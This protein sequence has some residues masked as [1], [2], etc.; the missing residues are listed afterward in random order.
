MGSRD[1]ELLTPAGRV[2]VTSWTNAGSASPWIWAWLRFDAAAIGLATDS[3]RTH[4]GRRAEVAG[5][6]VTVTA[7][8]MGLRTAWSSGWTARSL[9]TLPSSSEWATTLGPVLESH[10]L[11]PNRTNVQFARVA[12]RHTIE[13]AIWERGA[14]FT[15]VSGT[16]SC[17]AAAAAI[18]AERC[19]SPVTVRMPGGEM[20]VEIDEGWNVRL[21]GAARQVCS[22]EWYGE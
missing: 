10:P 19:E 20:L 15:L 6:D 5:H 12:D 8:S 7:V 22:G 1:F 4:R 14:G 11:Y 3:A 17:A 13:I 16:S 2:T 21:T 9:R 18:R